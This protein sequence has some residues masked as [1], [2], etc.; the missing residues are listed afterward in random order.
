MSCKATYLSGLRVLV[1]IPAVT[2]NVLKHH[3]HSVFL[4]ARLLAEV[5]AFVFHGVVVAP[6]VVGL[7]EQKYPPAALVADKSF[8]SLV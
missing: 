8:L 2:V 7:Q 4:L 6:E 1:E 3:D 5:D